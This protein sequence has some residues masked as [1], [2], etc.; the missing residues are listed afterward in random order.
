MAAVLHLVRPIAHT[1]HVM[2]RV[3]TEEFVS[4]LELVNRVARGVW[5]TVRGVTRRLPRRH[6]QNALR[7]V[8]GLIMVTVI[9]TWIGGVLLGFALIVVPKDPASQGRSPQSGA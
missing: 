5:V 8:T 2:S 3:F 1:E 6:R 4:R 7:Q 9:L